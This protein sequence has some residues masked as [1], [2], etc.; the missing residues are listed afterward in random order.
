LHPTSSICEATPIG[1]KNEAGQVHM[2]S[3]RKD[4]R[5]ICLES[6]E[7]AVVSGGGRNPGQILAAAD[8]P[9]SGQFS[10]TAMSPQ[11][12]LQNLL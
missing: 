4:T 6:A 11:I 1:S 5:H 9:Y 10:S 3:T 12:Q 2:T 7:S 8:H